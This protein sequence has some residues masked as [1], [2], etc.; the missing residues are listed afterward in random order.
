MKLP[1]IVNWIK[2]IFPNEDFE[3]TE[4]NSLMKTIK[5][6]ERLPSPNYKD[7]SQSM[8]NS[9]TS[10]RPL[11][12]NNI[13]LKVSLNKQI[14]S[15]G[16]ILPLVEYKRPI[17]STKEDNMKMYTKLLSVKYN[18][19][20]NIKESFCLTNKYVNVNIIEHQFMH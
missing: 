18:K 14:K 1:V 20:I 19:K 8:N 11:L 6:S 12:P 2:K 16:S 9:R 17:A 10:V 15:A 7:P 13:I 4:H 5:L 3:T